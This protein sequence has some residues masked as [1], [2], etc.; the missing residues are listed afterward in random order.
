MTLRSV[1]SV[2]AMCAL[3]FSVHAETDPTHGYWLTENGKAIVLFG[4]CGGETCGRMVWIDQ[5]RDPGGK[6]KLDVK[7]TDNAKRRRPLCG[8]TLLGG[9]KGGSD[10]RDGWIY[11]PRDGGTYSVN[12]EPVSGEKLKVRGYVGLKIL[13]SSQVWTRVKGDR[14]G[15]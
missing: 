2:L 11:N 10:E 14:G 7:N 9:L 15:C 6:L 12:V 8:L 4:P 13:G 3:P 1:I 5:P